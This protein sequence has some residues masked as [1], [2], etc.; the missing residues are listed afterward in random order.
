M[1]T[2]EL[3]AEVSRSEKALRALADACSSGSK[4]DTEAIASKEKDAA[5]AC[6][7]A[8]QLTNTVRKECKGDEAR[9][10]IA[11]LQ[12]RIRACEVR[13]TY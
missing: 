9:K 6:A 12:K 13:T 4:V 1:K 5:D 11:K 3:R 8:K 2:K 7:K 10:T